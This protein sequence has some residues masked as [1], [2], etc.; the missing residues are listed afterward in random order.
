MRGIVA[1]S[2]LN[3]QFSILSMPR[4][5]LTIEYAGTRYSG[6]QAQTNA[7]T[8]QGELA[9]AL[10]EAA[11][12][13]PGD[14]QGSGRTDAGV[15][16][17]QQ[18][19]H[20]DLRRALAPETLRRRVNDALPADIHVLAVQQVPHR[21]H[22][23]H[24][25][26]GRS[27]LYQVARRRTAFAKPFV[28]WVKDDLDIGRIREAAARFTGLHDFRSFTDADPDEGST[29]VRL[30]SLAVQE[31]G[32]LVLIRVAGSHFV[33][34]MVRRIVGVL[35]EVGAG[36]L[37]VEGAAGFLIE[38]SPDPARLTAPASG[39][40][41]ERVAYPGDPPDGPIRAAT[42]LWQCD[43]RPPGSSSSPRR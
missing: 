24:S 25:A 40:F 19:A 33:W 39:L 26:V 20:V 35:V 37:T 15:H 21:F 1:F 17:L 38:Q 41:L 3:S 18:V 4:Y 23:R 8:V 29:K 28:W 34:K 7:R 22:A 31:D 2:I 5:K 36:R 27:Y 11:G 14:F 43:L 10:E 30:E 32:D 42:P 12:E 6:W 16:A 13:T 9:R